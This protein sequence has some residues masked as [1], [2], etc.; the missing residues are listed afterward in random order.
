MPGLD[1]R[2]KQIAA[3]LRNG[4][5]SPTPTAREFL[6]WIGAKRRGY[7]IVSRLRWALERAGLVTEPD[8]ESAY[9]DSPI[10]FALAPSGEPEEPEVEGEGLGEAEPGPAEQYADPTYRVSKL[11]A[12]NSVPVSVKPDD[13]VSTAVTK[14]LASDYS[15]LPV[16]TNER[17][18]KGVISWRSI[19]AR[20]ATG[21]TAGTVRGFMDG[22]VEVE[23]TASLFSV[24][25]QVVVHDYVLVRAKDRRIVGIVTSSDLSLQFRQ[26]AE[27]FLLLG[28]IENHI[29]RILGEKLDHGDFQAACD[30]DGPDRDIQGVEDLTFGEY[31]RLLQ[32]PEK[33]EKLDLRLDRAV[34]VDRID[35]VRGIRNDVMHFDPDGIPDE[36][37]DVLRETSRFLQTLQAVGVT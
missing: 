15:Q 2:L 32:N 18:V 22:A 3:D 27:P 25:G 19:G 24:I 1:E 37:L 33:W 29:R 23:S 11:Q 31:V 8:F 26:L 16:M 20:L 9:I 28:E 13:D 21:S 17:D 30:P 35:R 34:L 36:D 4:E 14:M 6:S 5:P 12:A 10:T 7:W